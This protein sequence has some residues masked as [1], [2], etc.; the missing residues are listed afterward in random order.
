MPRAELTPAS[1]GCN[2]QSVSRMG[3]RNRRLTASI[4]GQAHVATQRLVSH[5]LDEWVTKEWCRIGQLVPM[6]DEGRD[7]PERHAQGDTSVAAHSV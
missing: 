7:L 6:T 2:V 3:A 4:I 1:P 5:F